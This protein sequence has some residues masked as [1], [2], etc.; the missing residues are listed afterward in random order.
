MST[1]DELQRGMVT[2]SAEATEAAGE[3]LAAELPRDVTLALSG[4]LGTGKTT[5]VRGLARGWG[6]RRAVTS[7]TFTLYTMYEGTRR[8]VHFDAYRLDSPEAAD[9]L[10]IEDFLQSPYCLVVEWPEKVAGWLPEPCFFLVFGIVRE[11][12]HAIRLTETPPYPA[13]P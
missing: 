1:M 13:E 9:D 6:I 11:N 8:L 4:Q 7:P 12:E 10:L 2:R 3:G 5:F